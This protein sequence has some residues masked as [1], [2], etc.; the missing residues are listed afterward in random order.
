M[1]LKRDWWR[2]LLGLFV[3]WLVFFMDLDGRSFASHLYRIVN[4]PETHELGD[5][6][7]DKF[8]SLFHGVS[9]RLGH[10]YHGFYDDGYDSG[11]RGHSHR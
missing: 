5:A 10:V 2:I 3:I 1:D 6:I 11:Y 9:D 7:G 8:A 4:T